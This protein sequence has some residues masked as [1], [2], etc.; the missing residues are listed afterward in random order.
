MLG[1]V[2]WRCKNTGRAIIWCSDHRDLAHYDGEVA[3]EAALSIEVGD[4][5]EATLMPSRSVRRC[6]DLKLVEA[7]YM[8]GVAHELTGRKQAIAAA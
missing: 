6:I 7:A 1:V 8:P 4:L 2:I 5:V 3:G